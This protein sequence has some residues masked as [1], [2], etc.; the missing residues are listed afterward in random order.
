MIALDEC[1]SVSVLRECNVS[2]RA[3][4]ARC[5]DEHMARRRFFFL[6]R[7][8]RQR[9]QAHRLLGGPGLELRRAGRPASLRAGCPLNGRGRIARVPGAAPRREPEFAT[10][11]RWWAGERAEGAGGRGRGAARP[12]LR[13]TATPWCRPL[14]LLL[15]TNDEAPEP[16]RHK[17]RHTC[18]GLVAAAKGARKPD[19]P[20][21]RRT[22]GRGHQGPGRGCGERRGRER[23]AAPAQRREAAGGE[24]CE[25]SERAL[26]E[27]SD[28]DARWPSSTTRQTCGRREQRC[29]DR[30]LA[31]PE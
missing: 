20:V 24:E 8:A 17:P 27:A 30:R 2:G 18:R 19:S 6:I 9:T 15:A 11:D 14:A 25:R 21:P 5:V 16:S 13:P 31:G 1:S 4:S 12:A 10:R 28:D 3:P 26:V 29:V 22:P 7:P 23:P